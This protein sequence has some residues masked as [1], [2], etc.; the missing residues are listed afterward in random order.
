MTTST[1]SFPPVDDAL[2]FVKN[3]DWKEV[4]RRSRK[5]L[6]NVGLVIAVIGEKIHDA[7]AFLAQLWPSVPR[8][9]P[10]VAAVFYALTA[11]N[12]TKSQLDQ[13]IQCLQTGD[14]VSRAYTVDQE[15]PAGAG[16]ALGT[17][18][19]A[20]IHLQVI[21]DTL[22]DDE[23]PNPWIHSWCGVRLSRTPSLW[24]DPRLHNLLQR[25]VRSYQRLLCSTGRIRIGILLTNLTWA[26]IIP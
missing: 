3:I 17:I 19:S 12:V 18:T 23:M 8:L 5:G 4:S 20:I 11:M 15:Y 21:R 2:T 14:T 26:N 22:D 16:Y 24:N 9:T 13:V 6:N 25:T 10:G 1:P 7:G